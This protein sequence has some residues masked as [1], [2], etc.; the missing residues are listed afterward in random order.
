MCSSYGVSQ[1]DGLKPAAFDNYN[2]LS[3]FTVGFR[4]GAVGEI[5]PWMC[6]VIVFSCVSM[7]ITDV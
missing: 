2:H 7:V 4:I 1:G 5:R 3:K 6:D